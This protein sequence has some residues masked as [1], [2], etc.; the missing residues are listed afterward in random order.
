MTL[1]KQLV[2]GMVTVLIL[3]MICVFIIEF[4]TT[5]NNLEQQQRSEVSNTINT[6]GLA[7]APYLENKDTVAAE[8]VINALF[9][10]STYSVVR[11]RFLD[12]D[13][14]I[15]R[16]YPIKPSQVPQWFTNLNLFEPIHDRRV[17]TSGWLQLAEVEIVSHPGEAYAQL[18]Q[19]LIRLCLA[20]GSITLVGL[21]AIALIVRH[22][23]KPLQMIVQKM[24]QIARNQFGEPLPL[25]DTRDLTAV[26]EGINS[27]SAQVEKYFKAQA[28]EAQMLRERAYIDPVSQLGNRAYYMNQLN[29]WLSENAVGGVA[30]LQ[31]QFIKELYEEKGYEAGDGMVRDLA[32]QLKA[33]VTTPNATIARISTDE[34][35]LILPNLDESELR[36]VADG[37]INAIQVVNPDPTG[38]AAADASLG[39]VHNKESKTSTEMLSLLDNAVATS[40]ANPELK[41]GFVTSATHQ[42]VMGKQQWKALVEEAIHHDWVTFRFQAANHSD[43][44]TFHREVFSAIEKDNVRYS[45]NQYLFALEQLH[46]S[47]LFDQYVLQAMVEKLDAGEL[48]DTLAINIAQSSIEQPSFIRWVTQLLAR[49][50]TV[51]DKLH[52]EIP[53]SCFVNAP[54]H[55]ALFCHAVRSAGAGFGVDNYGRNFQSLDY[56]N[57]FRPDYVK[58][59]YLFTHHLDDE[60]QKFTLTSIS[61]TAHDLGVTTIAS[62]VETQVQLDFLSEHFIDVFQGFI[63]DR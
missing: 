18:W 14:E 36:L 48:T 23:L 31:A 59:D 43:G 4:K 22:A 53:E 17:V 7:L 63:V 44:Q 2:A 41:Y 27:M 56:I 1:Y 61:R 45:A 40:K 26:V 6:V 55:T 25:P 50:K 12:D 20:F 51:C 24:A 38:M 57:E 37:L 54:H 32:A 10:G 39:V 49:H 16:A 62:R 15:V 60:K 13:A 5:R 11:L 29:G 30:I 35:G 19:A 21:M 33:T 3:L 9:D 47:H 46:A 58:L 28:Q 42:V 34:F 52:F 8:S